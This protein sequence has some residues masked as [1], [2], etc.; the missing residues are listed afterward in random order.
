[1]E[2]DFELE[3]EL[4]LEL[5]EDDDL[6]VELVELVELVDFAVELVDEVDFFAGADDVV[7]LGAGLGAGL[8]TLREEPPPDLLMLMLDLLPL[9][10]HS[11]VPANCSNWQVLPAKDL[12]P[13]SGNCFLAHRQ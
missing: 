12:F 13:V 7:F 8:L 5:V 10:V 11:H 3:L 6:L 9:V 1:M 2:D 4:E